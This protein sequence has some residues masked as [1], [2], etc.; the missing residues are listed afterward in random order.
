MLS[1]TLYCVQKRTMSSIIDESALSLSLSLSHG[2]H[3]PLTNRQ[4]QYQSKPNNTWT[5]RCGV[6]LSENPE[7]TKWTN[8][9]SGSEWVQITDSI[10]Q[11][12]KWHYVSSNLNTNSEINLCECELPVESG[13]ERGRKGKRVV[14]RWTIIGIFDTRYSIRFKESNSVSFAN[15]NVFSEARAR[16]C[17]VQRF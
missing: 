5:F 2:K 11:Q 3:R 6:D 9:K 15:S 17:N 16:C 8:E 14:F 1:S 13:W 12:S 10:L 7:R 4:R